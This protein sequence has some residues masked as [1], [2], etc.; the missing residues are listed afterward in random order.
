V[1]PS[2][3][4][5]LSR[6]PTLQTKRQAVTQRGKSRITTAPKT[7]ATTTGQGAAAGN[8]ALLK[9]SQALVKSPTGRRGLKNT[10]FS[11][12]STRDPATRSLAKSTFS[13]SY[14]KNRS[15]WTH[16]WRRHR[17]RNHV[18]VLGFYGPVFWPYAYDDFI[19][20]TFWPYAYDDFWPYAYDDFYDGIFGAY[21]PDYYAY[22]GGYRT[23][24]GYGPSRRGR[25]RTAVTGGIC[26]GQTPGLT[27][28]P[29]ERIA[30]QVGPDQNERALL[31]DLKNATGSALTILQAA[32]PTE[33]ASTPPG[34]LAD[35]RERV[36]A[37]L[38]AVQLIRPP[39]DKFYDALTDEQKERFNELDAQARQNA[40]RQADLTKLCNSA[41]DVPI[42]RIESSLRLNNTQQT[43]LSEL[44]D[45]SAKAGDTLAQNCPTAETLT[46]TGRIA[47][48]EQRLNAMLQAVDTVQPAL[49]KFYQSL[50][51]EQK[52]QFNRLS[53]TPA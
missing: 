31:D 18:F 52:A 7:T 40:A 39:L 19:D 30:Q 11:S 37:M 26:S 51:D 15:A 17:H 50:S 46:P 14:T 21:A 2:A 4:S 23:A 12:L 22:A 53:A 42:A 43:A 35:M 41:A 13:G 38:Q 16:D 6:A 28:F 33:L 44:K 29:I 36:N 20:Y 8:R 32:C 5:R 45:A 27:D 3:T 10:A 25:M 48:M 47:A 9:S 1:R 49:A 34:R 24:Y